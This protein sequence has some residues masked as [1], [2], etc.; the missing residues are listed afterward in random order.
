MLFLTSAAAASCR[1]REAAVVG[2]GATALSKG[3]QATAAA[4]TWLQTKLDM[5]VKPKAPTS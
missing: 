4:E 3:L 5:W 1:K 2:R